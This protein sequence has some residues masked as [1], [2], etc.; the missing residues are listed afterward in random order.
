MHLRALVETRGVILNIEFALSL[1]HAG[2][3]LVP[4]VLP[5][6]LREHAVL[7]GAKGTIVELERGS[8]SEALAAAVLIDA[9]WDCIKHCAVA[10]RRRHRGYIDGIRAL[11]HLSLV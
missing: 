6:C 7:D 9:T 5:F 4:Q 8:V 3:L 1:L 2:S 10:M 11:Q